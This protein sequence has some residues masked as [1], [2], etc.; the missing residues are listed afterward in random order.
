[1]RL[2]LRWVSRP[3]PLLSFLVPR[4]DGTQR[5]NESRETLRF[6]EATEIFKRHRHSIDCHSFANH[7]AEL[8]PIMSTSLSNFPAS[9]WQKFSPESQR[10]LSD[11]CSSFDQA[12]QQ[13]GQPERRLARF[14]SSKRFGRRPVNLGVIGQRESPIGRHRDGTTSTNPCTNTS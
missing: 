8:I 14:L 11:R 12:W 13:G 9:S 3:E 10:L 2:R 7:R 1:M 6:A 4:S 5:G